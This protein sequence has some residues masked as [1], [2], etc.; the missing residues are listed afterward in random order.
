MYKSYS[1]KA[2]QNK[3]EE[4]TPVALYVRMSTDYQKYSIA[5]QTDELLRYA[6]KRGMKVIKTYKDAGKSGL[7]IKNR[8]G[9]SKLIE[10]IE[11]G[12]TEFKAVLVYDVSRWGRFQD[13]DESAYY[14][15]KCKKAGINIHYC[16]ETFQND[17]STISTIM[18][19]LKRAM[20]GEYS[21]ELSVKVFKGQARVVRKGFCAGGSA[22]YGMR[23]LLVDG[24]GNPKQVLNSGEHKNISTDRTIL[25][26]GPI[27][28]CKTI[29]RIFDLF[30][31]DNK[32]THEIASILNKNFK[33]TGK[34]SPWRHSSILNILKNEKYIGNNIYNRKSKKF[35]KRTVMNSPEE[36]IRATNVFEPIVSKKIFRKAQKLIK[37]Q[38]RSMSD[39]D[40]LKGLERLYKRKGYLSNV[41]INEDRKIPSADVFIKRF[42]SL[43]AAYE[44]VGFHHNQK[45]RSDE[46]LLVKLKNLFNKHG[47]LSTTLIAH[48]PNMPCR[49]TYSRRFGS[50]QKAYELV[51]YTKE[52]S[53]IPKHVMLD[54]LIKL[55]KRKNYLSESLIKKSNLTP[56][57]NTYRSV[58]GS[59]NVAYKLIGYDPE[60]RRVTNEELIDNLKQIYEEHGYLSG[61]LIDKS[62]YKHSRAIYYNRFGKLINAYALAGYNTEA[63]GMSNEIM[64]IRLKELFEEKGFLSRKIIDQCEGIPCA[65]TYVNRI[66]NIEKVYEMVGFIKPE[67][68]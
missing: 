68:N 26:P 10:D 6:N 58:F 48:S 63:Y 20:A 41:L 29:D 67:E 28:E 8:K 49:D 15:Y 60:T 17:N 23:R 50:I 31:N 1:Q 36:W 18:K 5:N 46:E 39:E 11:N 62:K 14:E 44:L 16:A 34:T 22:G 24:D 27:E 33:D 59:L 57:A 38:R 7:Q 52:K 13:A 51:G 42:K 65:Q 54:Q 55:L 35:R 40:M 9:L 61:T 2:F 21:R 47:Y 19:N 56:G 12:Q 3:S 37:E 30:V 4:E 66:G 32:S 64:M 45:G 43:Y 25:I 53:L